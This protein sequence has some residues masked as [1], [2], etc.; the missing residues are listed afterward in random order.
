[1]VARS[2]TPAVGIDEDSP[3]DDVNA[4]NGMEDTGA[5]TALR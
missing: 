4:Q 3:S 1:M 5:P 2:R